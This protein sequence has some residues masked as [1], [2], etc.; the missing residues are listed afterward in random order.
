MQQGKQMCQATGQTWDVH[1]DKYLYTV[2][3]MPS[4]KAGAVL[5]ANCMSASVPLCLPQ[6]PLLDK[7]CID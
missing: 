4:T 6:A 5:C 1:N 3:C 2:T 7:S